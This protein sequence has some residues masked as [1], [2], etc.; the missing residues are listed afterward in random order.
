MDPLYFIST[1]GA[2]IELSWR[3]FQSIS[4]RNEEFDDL[5]RELSDLHSTAEVLRE[6]IWTKQLANTDRLDPAWSAIRNTLYLTTGSLESLEQ[7]LEPLI[8]SSERWGARIRVKVFA[9]S[10]AKERAKLQALEKSIHSRRVELQ[11]SANGNISLELVLRT[12]LYQGR[13]RGLY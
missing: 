1:V 3:L 11:R 13:I 2:V 9:F 6:I 10:K 7:C 8:R 5:Q 4:R 12:P